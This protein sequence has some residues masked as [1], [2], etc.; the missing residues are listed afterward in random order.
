M[1][2]GGVGRIKS[3]ANVTQYHR[4]KNSWTRRNGRN[5]SYT[6]NCGGV[7]TTP[8]VD[9]LW[10][11]AYIG[12]YTTQLGQHRHLP[13]SFLSLASGGRRELGPDFTVP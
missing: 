9:R 8:N 13:S 2:E 4:C 5:S 10:C 12:S 11:M 3:R 7:D 1:I 6:N